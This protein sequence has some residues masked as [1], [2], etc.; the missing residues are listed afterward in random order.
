MLAEVAGSVSTSV[1]SFYL[2][3]GQ[4]DRLQGLTLNVALATYAVAS[5]CTDCLVTGTLYCCLRQE[6][7]VNGKEDGM[8][9]YVVRLAV[10]T[11]AYTAF[12]AVTGGTC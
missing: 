4:P 1:V 8:A 5:A 7:R 12:F 3:K 11:A 2:W 10:R 9:R 6:L